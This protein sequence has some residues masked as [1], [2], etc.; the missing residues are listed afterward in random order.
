VDASAATVYTIRLARRDVN[1]IQC[2]GVLR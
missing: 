1:Q 2:S